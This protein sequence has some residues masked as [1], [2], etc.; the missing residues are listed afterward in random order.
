MLKISID[1]HGLSQLAALEKRLAAAIEPALDAETGVVLRQKEKQIGKTYSRAI[2]KG[3]N[4]KPKW[5]RSGDWLQGQSVQS[6]KG[7]R[8][9]TTT[10]NAAKYEERLAN[11]NTGADGVNR[12]NAAAAEAARVTEPQR[13]KVFEQ[14]LRNELGAS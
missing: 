6:S 9:I 13:G 1:S 11:L 3:K 12:S 14:T 7:E 10:G 2:P 5:Q 4:G 8:K